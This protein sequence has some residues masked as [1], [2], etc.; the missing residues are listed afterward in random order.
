MGC[1]F[2][3]PGFTDEHSYLFLARGVVPSPHGPEHDANEAIGECR[4][5]TVAELRRMVAENEIRDAN[6]LSTFAR[7]TVLGFI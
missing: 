1:F 7:L 4:P 3:S 6:T 5:F 2:S